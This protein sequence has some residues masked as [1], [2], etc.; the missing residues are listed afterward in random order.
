M[1]CMRRLHLLIW[2]LAFWAQVTY[3][4]LKYPIVGTYKKKSAQGMAIFGDYAY[5]ANE[6]GLCRILD[7]KKGKVLREF[8][9]ESSSKD[10]HVNSAS[11]GKAIYK[12]TH[13]PLIYLSEC[14][15]KGRCFVERITADSSELVQ[16]IQATKKGKIER[17]TDWVVDNERNCLYAITRNRKLVLDSVGNIKS[18]ITKYRLP[19][20]DEGKN[21]ILAEQDVLD[22]FEVLFPNILQGCKIRGKYLYLV[23]GLQQT[24]SY[25]KESQRAIIVID[26]QKKRIKKIKD[27]T[28]VTT[29]EPEDIDFYKG[30]CLMYCGQEGGLYEIK[31]K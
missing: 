19:S 16:T 30:K 31:V 21:I 25:S 14:M 27:L 1:N 22:Q 9:F 17:M 15:V 6:G 3:A 5:L 20:V 29:N 7:L 18:Y 11:F 28:Y 26:L 23:T 8:H 4:Q 2:L 24:Y 12:G 10:N 13:V